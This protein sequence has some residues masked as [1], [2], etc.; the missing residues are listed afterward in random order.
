VFLATS[1]KKAPLRGA[2]LYFHENIVVPVWARL[3]V[4]IALAAKG[5]CCHCWG[6]ALEMSSC[7]RF[8]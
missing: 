5:G 6:T 3:A 8:H 2:G 4:V 1:H 7:I